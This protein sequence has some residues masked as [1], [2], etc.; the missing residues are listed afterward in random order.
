MASHGHVDVLKSSM[1]AD[2]STNPPRRA[3]PKLWSP[4]ASAD[5]PALRPL[6]GG[7]P[8]SVVE[9]V[10]AAESIVGSAPHQ[11]S[12]ARTESVDLGRAGDRP[13]RQR[14]TGRAYV[15]LPFT[16][17]TAIAA[18]KPAQRSG[19][20]VRYSCTIKEMPYGDRPRERLVS[21]GPQAL[22]TAELLAILI[23]VGNAERSAVSLGEQLIAHFGNVNEVAAASVEQLS[24][25]KGIGGAKATQIKAAIEF[26]RRLSLMGGDDRPTIGDPSDAAN[27]VMSDLRYLKKETLKSLLLDNKNR[28]IGIKTVSIGDLTQ[29]IAHPREVYKDAVVASAASVILAH[30]HPSGDPTPSHDDIVITKRLMQAGDILGIELLDHLIIGDGSFVSLQQR[31]LV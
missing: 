27:L 16:R 6:N 11:P 25:V 18:K 23:R 28:V 24:N 22:T 15:A 8:A 2:S 1:S 19:E 26:G 21:L 12:P 7:R 10:P 14:S 30:N 31:G 29:S 3:M 20:V 13:R 5:A 17:S 9:S 4:S